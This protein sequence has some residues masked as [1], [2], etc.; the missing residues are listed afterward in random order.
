[1][2]VIDGGRA[3]RLSWMEAGVDSL[4]GVEGGRGWYAAGG[5]VPRSA[6]LR[7]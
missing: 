3:E 6:K 2:D 1:M 5:F 4:L 7:R